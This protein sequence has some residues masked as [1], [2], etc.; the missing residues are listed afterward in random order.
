MLKTDVVAMSVTRLVVY[1]LLC[2]QE[3]HTDLAVKDCA[4]PA[5]MIAIQ[6]GILEFFSFALCMAIIAKL[7]LTNPLH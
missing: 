4:I 1:E 3:F 2:D 6:S 7:L 5:L